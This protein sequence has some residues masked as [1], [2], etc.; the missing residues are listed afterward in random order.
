MHEPLDLVTRVTTP[1]AEKIPSMT[2]GGQTETVSVR[3]RPI[4]VSVFWFS[5]FLVFQPKLYFQPKQDVLP[6]IPHFG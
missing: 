5:P 3:F 1:P 4:S 6:E 2:H